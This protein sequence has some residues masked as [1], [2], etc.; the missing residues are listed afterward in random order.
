MGRLAYGLEVGSSIGGYRI[1]EPTGR[2]GMGVVYLATHTRLRRKAALKIRSPELADDEIFRER[3]IRESRLAASLDHPSVIPIYDA[4]E[5]DGVL[6]LA[7]R[8]V[9][10]LDLERATFSE[11]QQPNQAASVCLRRSERQTRSVGEE[12]NDFR[13]GRRVDDRSRVPHH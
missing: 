4:D 8:Y 10:G 12:H 9:Q 1:D 7:M 3:F 6:Y 13:P 5:E 2:G 11:P